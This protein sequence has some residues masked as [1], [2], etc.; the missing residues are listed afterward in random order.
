MENQISKLWY[1]PLLK[2]LIMILLAILIFMSP[3]GTLL[4]WALY[5][6]IGFL[7]SGVILIYQGFSVRSTEQG[8]GWKVFEGILDLF[9]GFILVANPALT[10]AVVPFVIGFWGVITGII[11]FVSGF[12]GKDGK[13]LRI[14]FGILIFI[15]STIIMFNP[16]SAA[17]TIVI[18][19]GILLLLAGI[20]NLIFAFQ[21]RSL[22]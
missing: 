11:L 10:A 3:A 13:G 9:L 5:I 20:G 21:A 22:K 2:G 12:T 4:A 15:F 8:W 6:G 19:I 7:I 1:M 16:V 17:M 14:V 18:W